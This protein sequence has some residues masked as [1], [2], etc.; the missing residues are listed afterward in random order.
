MF[1]QRSLCIANLPP[2]ATEPD[3]FHFFGAYGALASVSIVWDCSIDEKEKHDSRPRIAFVV[4]GDAAAAAA[5]IAAPPT[6]H[7]RLLQVVVVLLLL[8]L[9][10]LL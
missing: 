7:G 5:A 2:A 3:L 10:L 6:M 8:L 4:M 9:L 1:T